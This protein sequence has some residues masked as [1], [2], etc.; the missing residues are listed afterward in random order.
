MPI[1]ALRIARDAEIVAYKKAHPTETQTAIG[2]RFGLSQGNV[3][4][5]LRGAG[6]KS[7]NKGKWALPRIQA[8]DAEIVAYATA[9]PKRW[10]LIL[11][12]EGLG[13]GRGSGRLVYVGLG[14][15]FYEAREAERFLATEIE[16]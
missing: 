11:A 3:S 2:K 9:H 5:A 1:K 15:D 12:K 8:R 16:A 13:M 4:Y 14:V 10:E 7:F 6:I